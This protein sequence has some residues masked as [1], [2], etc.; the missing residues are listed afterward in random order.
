MPHMV[1]EYVEGLWLEVL[2]DDGSVEYLPASLFHK[3][4]DEKDLHQYLTPPN[5]QKPSDTDE[6]PQTL[7]NVVRGVGAR[8]SA[9]G[10]LDATEW[11]VLR[12]EQHAKNYIKEQYEVDPETGE[13]EEEEDDGNGEG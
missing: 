7:Y 4:P 13:P 5:I 12:T 6:D 3:L 10:Y 2:V 11:F 8:L 9:P 1:P